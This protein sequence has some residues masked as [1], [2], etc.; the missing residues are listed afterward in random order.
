M[1]IET[2]SYTEMDLQ[3]YDDLKKNMKNKYNLFFADHGVWP[4]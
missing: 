3:H 2:F 4:W 1:K